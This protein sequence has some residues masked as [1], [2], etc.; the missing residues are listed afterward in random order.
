MRSF[1]IF[2]SY[3]VIPIIYKLFIIVNKYCVPKLV[4]GFSQAIQ[5]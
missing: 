1:D 2:Y 4:W 3:I 5:L